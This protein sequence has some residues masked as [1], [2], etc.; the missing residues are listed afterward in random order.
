MRPKLKTS[1]IVSSLKTA[2]SILIFAIARST[3]AATLWTG[4]NITF[5]Q[6]ATTPKDVL[7]SGAVSLTRAGNHWLYNPDGGDTGPAVGTPSDTLWAFGTLANYASLSYQTFDSY[8]NGNLSAVLLPNKPMVVH[9]VNEDIY[10]A[11]TFTAWPAGGGF[12]AYTRS[13]PAA[14]APTPTVAITN[15]ASSAVFAAPANVTIAANASVSA[16]SVTNVA[17]FGNGSPLGSR[18]ATPFSITTGNLSAGAYSL[19]AVATAAGISA[20]SSVV[21]INVVSPVA[22]SL[23][24]AKTGNGKFSFSYSANPGLRYVVQ[25]SS[26]LVNWTP[27]ITNVAPSNPAFFTNNLNPIGASFYRVGR[28]PNP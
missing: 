24:S 4:P 5:T 19:T 25:N 18:Q 3:P 21:N 17:F 20:T 13:T 11:L 22:T 8:R 15:P 1:L 14:V 28:L 26:N 10:L 12:F 6:S 23:S 2:L 27:I 7:I 9:L 16:G